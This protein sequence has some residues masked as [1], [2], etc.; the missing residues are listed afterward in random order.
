MK[1]MALGAHPDD[2]VSGSPD[3]RLGA[4]NTVID[5]V[6]SMT[7]VRKVVNANLGQVTHLCGPV[8]GPAPDVG[9]A[10][11]RP[12]PP[13]WRKPGGVRFKTGRVR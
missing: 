4:Y 9:E 6:A 5:N 7:A 8:A 3:E 2:K 11:L 12:L 13:R 1:I 10:H